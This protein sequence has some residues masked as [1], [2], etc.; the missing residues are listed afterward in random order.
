MTLMY[1]FRTCAWNK[2]NN[3]VID[4]IQQQID[5]RRELLVY[6]KIDLS[7]FVSRSTDYFLT[8]P[9]GGGT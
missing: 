1:S 7:G 6:Q 2:K 3:L 8:L 9:P 5:Q 4:K